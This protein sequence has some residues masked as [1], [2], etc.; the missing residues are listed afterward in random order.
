MKDILLRDQTLHF[1]QTISV[2]IRCLNSVQNIRDIDNELGHIRNALCQLVETIKTLDNLDYHQSK[3]IHEKL[4]DLEKLLLK[5]IQELKVNRLENVINTS[6]ELA[7]TAN[8][9]FHTIT[10][11]PNSPIRK[12]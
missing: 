1:I 10:R 6:L 5:L 8:E 11:L 2:F 9:L 12:I 7:R 3:R 4:S